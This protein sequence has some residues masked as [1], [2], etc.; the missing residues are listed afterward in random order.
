MS[1]EDD[2]GWEPLRV[3]VNVTSVVALN[4]ALRTFLLDELLPAAIEW[5]S[6]ALAVRPIAEALRAARTCGSALTLCSSKCYS[7]GEIPTC[8]LDDAGEAAPIPPELLRNLTTCTSCAGG[9][10]AQPAGSGAA[11]GAGFVLFVSAVNSSRCNSGTTLAYA[12]TCQRDQ[13]DRP[14]FG[15]ANFCAGELSSAPSHWSSQLAMAVHELLHALGFSRASWALFRFP[16][17]SPRTPRGPDGLPPYT[18]TVCVDGVNRTVRA[19]S[20]NTLQVATERG[21]HVARLVT[22]RL[23]RVARDIFGCDSLVGVELENQP[24]G[25]GACWGADLP[26]ASPTLI[27]HTIEPHGQP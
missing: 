10:I 1:E 5:I 2:V 7:E 17:G 8:G 19:P 20:N 24:T 27:S 18:Q 12:A 4:P 23:V 16:D 25:A 22:P 14:I 13:F 11:P 3:Q 6:S 15:Y 26:R 9:C 21:G